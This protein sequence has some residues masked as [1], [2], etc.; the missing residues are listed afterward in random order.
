MNG[1]CDYKSAAE[2]EK[3]FKVFH[4]LHALSDLMMLPSEMLSDSSTRKE[5]RN[6]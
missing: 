2:H 6:Q 1:V 3:S 5:V 4:L